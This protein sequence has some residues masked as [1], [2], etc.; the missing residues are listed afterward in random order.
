MRTTN[1]THKVGLLALKEAIGSSLQAAVVIVLIAP[2][3][4]GE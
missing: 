3:R 2:Y 4:E 1:C